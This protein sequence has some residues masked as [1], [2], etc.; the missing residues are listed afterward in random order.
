MWSEAVCSCLRRAEKL[1]AASVRPGGEVRALP[2][3]MGGD[4]RGKLGCAHPYSRG[5]ENVPTLCLGSK[6]CN[7]P[8]LVMPLE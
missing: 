6:V 2:C 1:P 5:C 8:A 3:A 4:A 7:G